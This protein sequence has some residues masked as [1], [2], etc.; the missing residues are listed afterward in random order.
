MGNLTAVL[1]NVMVAYDGNVPIL[2]TCRKTTM[3]GL[4]FSV[5]TNEVGYRFLE[6]LYWLPETSDPSG[7]LSIIS[8]PVV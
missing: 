5:V 3:T 7:N 2:N 4:S 1:L 8:A 6:Q